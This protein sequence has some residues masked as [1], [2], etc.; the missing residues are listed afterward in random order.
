MYLQ[1]A[2]KKLVLLWL[3]LVFLIINFKGSI[4]AQDTQTETIVKEDYIFTIESDSEVIRQVVFGGEIRCGR[5]ES[6]R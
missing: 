5:R 3:F 2:N 1:F 4:E 6:Y